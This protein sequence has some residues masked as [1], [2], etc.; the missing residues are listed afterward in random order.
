MKKLNFLCFF[1]IVCPLIANAKESN[2]LE[3]V[4]VTARP[5]RSQSLEHIAQPVSVINGDELELKKSASIGETL[6]LEPG[7][8]SSNFGVYASRPIIRGLGGSRVLVAE[9]G[10]SS[11]DVSTISGDHAVTIDPLHTEQIEIL[12][13]PATLLYGSG[14]SGGM[15]NVVTNRIPEYLSDFELKLN[16]GFNANNLE[17]SYAFNTT[18]SIDNFTFHVD[19]TR[20]DAKNYDSSR[21]TVGNSFYD[22]TD[23]N[24]GTSLVE[25]WGFAGFSLG[26]FESTHGI[27]LDFDNPDEQPF[28]DTEQDR[29]DLAAQVNLNTRYIESIRFRAAHNDYQHIEFEDSVTP[30]TTFDNNQWEGR[31]EI[32]HAKLGLWTGTLGTQLGLRSLKAV[33]DEAFIPPTKSKT[34]AVFIH[35][36]IDLDRFYF[37]MSGR[38]EKQRDEPSSASTV[39]NDAFSVSVGSHYQLTDTLSLGIALSRNQR[40]PTVEELFANGP[41]LA[42]AAFELGAKDLDIETQNTMD[43]SV[44]NESGR[45]T[46][47]INLFLNY[48]EDYIFLQG[49]DLDNNGTVDEVDETGTAA[50]ELR[51]LQYQ[52]ANTLFYGTEAKSSFKIFQNTSSDLDLSFFGD[53]VRAKRDGDI[54]ISRISPARLG[55]GLL[56][57][58]DQLTAKLDL[59]T[60]LDQKDSGPLETDTDGYTLLNMSMNYRLNNDSIP[61]AIQ[62]KANNLLDEYGERHTSLIKERSPIMGRAISI[63]LSVNF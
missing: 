14:A 23:F 13:G 38:Y 28:I 46:W 19:G 39:N 25:H 42:T 35:E 21:G 37:E 52:Q 33:G 40:I 50:G 54:N 1:A 55:M 4:T 8:T 3:D 62:L 6:S 12:R 60:V 26:H 32:Q 27:P 30:G 7:V 53:W 10:I 36:A 24:V 57:K 44:A 5:L 17:K 59:I 61:L 9:G 20:R 16:T 58:R 11:L 15:V 63:G 31:L 29:I 41:H 43:L 22:N 45:W 51:L 48:I 47:N 56:Y 49:L 2:Y 34:V 18:G